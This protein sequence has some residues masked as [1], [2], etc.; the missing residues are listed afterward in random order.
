MTYDDA[1]LRSKYIKLKQDLYAIKGVCDEMNG[2]YDE[3]IIT[4]KETLLINND[5]VGD[6]NCKDTNVSV[7]N[8]LNHVIN[9]IDRKL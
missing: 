3:Y 5:V 4:S 8:E 6:C 1:A 7:K 9:M 2:T